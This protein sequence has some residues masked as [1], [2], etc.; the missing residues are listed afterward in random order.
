MTA[1]RYR[2]RRAGFSLLEIVLALA[3]AAI[4][5]AL[6]S[7]LVGIAN[8]SAAAARDLTKAQL[9][10]ESVM[11]EFAAGVMAP[12][13]TSG[14]SEIDPLWAYQAEVTAGAGGSDNLYAITVTVTHE[15]DD[16]SPASFSLTQW[17]FVPPEPVDDTTTE[18]DATSSST[19][20]GAA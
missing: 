6:L 9:V 5:M 16:L 10:A 1:N 13:T 18:A 4:A 19:P 17:L 12:Q 14:V 11:A 15:V 2:E 7:Q 20:G 8:R 3:I